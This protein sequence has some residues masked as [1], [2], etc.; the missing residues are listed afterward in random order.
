MSDHQVEKTEEQLAKEAEDKAL[1]AALNEGFEH[2]VV[3]AVPAIFRFKSTKEIVNG[4]ETVIPARKPIE[5]RIPAPTAWGVMLALKDEKQRDYILDILQNNIA[6]AVRAQ[7]SPDDLSGPAPVT[8]QEELDMSKL[9]LAYLANEPRGARKGTGIAKETWDAF[10]V[11]YV[12]TM[13]QKTGLEQAKATYA[14]KILV[15]RFNPVRT[16]K[17]VISKLIDRLGVWAEKSDNVADFQDVFDYLVSRAE[18]L[19]KADSEA[20]LDNI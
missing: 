17:P 2:P 9:T 18:T 15:Q 1:L 7:L 19:I 8:K 20:L 11:D 3:H 14:G 4:V 16:N 12:S 6:D 10:L 5:L 13:V